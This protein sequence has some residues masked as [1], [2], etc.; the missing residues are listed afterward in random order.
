M[1]PRPIILK[2]MLVCLIVALLSLPACADSQPDAVSFDKVDV[3]GME[4]F[5]ENSKG[6][7]VVLLFW[8]T[9]C[10]ACRTELPELEELKK[11][12]SEDDLT[13]LGVSLDERESDLAIFFSSRL[14]NYQILLGNKELAQ[15]YK[16]REIPKLVI[17][18]QKGDT[19]FDRPGA[20]PLPEL[21]KI[22]DGLI[23]G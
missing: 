20:F 22:I 21:Q 7:V 6:K 4:K 12:Y 16:V 3:A 14:P 1:N 11:L 10:P 13:I 19:V 2:S 8:A 17:Y 23:P 5:L 15:E 18:D 9:W